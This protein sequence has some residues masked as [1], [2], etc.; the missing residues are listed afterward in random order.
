MWEIVRSAASTR[1]F[2]TCQRGLSGSA[3]A[4]RITRPRTGPIRKANRHPRLRSIAL[5]KMNVP[6]VPRIAPAQ[7]VPLIAMSTLPRKRAGIS[8]S[9]AELM[10]A[11]SPPIPIPAINRVM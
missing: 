9:I 10:A 4:H 5:R 1:P 6:G 2:M 7:Y 3:A 11:Y 8:S